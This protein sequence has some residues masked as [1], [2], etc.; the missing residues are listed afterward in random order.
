MSEMRFPRWVAAFGVVGG[1]AIAL[2]FPMIILIQGQDLSDVARIWLS[3]LGL[4]LGVLLA[5]ASAVIGITIPSA[6]SRGISVGG[7]RAGSRSVRRV[8]PAGGAGP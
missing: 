2:G 7:A 5:G 8:L 1:V 3:I 6:V 4:L